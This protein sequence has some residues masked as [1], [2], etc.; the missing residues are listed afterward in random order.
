MWRP[1]GIRGRAVSTAPA[2]ET[3]S[4]ACTATSAPEASTAVR[5]GSVSPHT[6]TV[7]PAVDIVWARSAARA[8]SNRLAAAGE[9]R[10]TS[11]TWT[12]AGMTRSA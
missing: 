8:R 6:T 11:T 10:V 12:G 9:D 4:G 7:S 3:R 2:K 5:N 1:S